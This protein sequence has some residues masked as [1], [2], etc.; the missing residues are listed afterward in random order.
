M[1][2]HYGFSVGH[3]FHKRCVDPWLLL[4]RTCPFCKYDVVL[5]RYVGDQPAIPPVVACPSSSATTSPVSDDFLNHDAI[6]VAMRNSAS[7]EFPDRINFA[8]FNRRCEEDARQSTSI[9][10][11]TFFFND[12][13]TAAVPQHTPNLYSIPV[14]ARTSDANLGDSNLS[15][16]NEFPSEAVEASDSNAVSGITALMGSNRILNARDS[17]QRSSNGAQR[18]PERP[19]R[20]FRRQQQKSWRQMK[21]RKFY[22]G[23]MRQQLLLNGEP[24]MGTAMR[25]GET[26]AELRKRGNDI[27]FGL[28]TVV[29]SWA[30]PATDT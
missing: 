22:A 24:A 3:E 21:S 6:P 8:G 4:N 10:H 7:H 14:R 20:L 29:P 5:E 28:W 25:F 18:L 9:S 16:R 11:V 17:H 2:R 13:R 23:K 27:L 1:A 26:D 30:I 15:P 12:W 19:R